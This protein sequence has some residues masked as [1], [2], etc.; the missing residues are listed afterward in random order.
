MYQL[1]D[2]YNL[3]DTTSDS[4]IEETALKLYNALGHSYSSS[5]ISA[6][7][8]IIRFLNGNMPIAEILTSTCRQ[9]LQNVKRCA[10]LFEKG[11]SEFYRRS[12]RKILYF[13]VDLMEVGTDRST[14][15]YAI[16]LTMSKFTNDFS[17][18]LFR[19]LDAYM[20]SFHC[21]GN[22][23]K[24]ILV[25]SDWFDLFS[26]DNEML[27]A[28][29]ASNLS[30]QN[31]TEFLG[32]FIYAAVRGYYIH[33][34]SKT[35]IRYELLPNIMDF[36]SRQEM[37][38]EVWR[39]YSEPIHLYKDDYIE[40]NLMDEY[41]DEIIEG[42]Q[43]IDFDLLEYELGKIGAFEKRFYNDIDFEDEYQDPEYDVN[44]IDEET[45]NDPVKLLEWIKEQEELKVNQTVTIRA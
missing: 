8:N 23:K 43:E 9:Y 25:L 39:V 35:Y 26:D 38:D 13:A 3:S 40:S 4:L 33:T 10:F 18:V 11:S 36:F 17:V 6:S 15:A 29:H 28:V 20:F 44:D 5:A 16:H 2:T 27:N 37:E 41:S 42:N 22:D 7:D 1:H 19:H 34:L 24:K 12:T 30:A 31:T 32:D 21:K 45:I 14:E